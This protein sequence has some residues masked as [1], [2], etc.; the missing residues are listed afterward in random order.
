M[1]VTLKEIA[2][3]VEV[4]ALGVDFTDEAK[5]VDTMVQAINWAAENDLDVLTYSS[6]QFSE[7]SEKILDEA[8]DKAVASGIVTT[9]IHYYNPN[10]ILPDGMFAYRG[11]EDHNRREPDLN[12][13]HWDYNVLMVPRYLEYV[14]ASEEER[15]KLTPP[16]L[17]IS[18][19]SPVTAGFVALLKSVKSDLTPAECKRILMDTSR[20]MVYNGQEC[21]RVPD[22]YE[23]VKLVSGTTSN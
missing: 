18:S 8:V 3:E 2:P 17:S 4:Y 6:G 16:F 9:F 21:P 14:A 23:A 22:I 15:M 20:R 10:N 1:A 11:A 5:K 13:L 7:E 12:I 19:T